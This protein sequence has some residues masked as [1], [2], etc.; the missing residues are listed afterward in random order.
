MAAGGKMSRFASAPRLPRSVRSTASRIPACRSA[1]APPHVPSSVVRLPR[2]RS[3]L[4]QRGRVGRRSAV[5]ARTGGLSSAY[6]R[7]TTTAARA[8]RWSTTRS[9]GH[10]RSRASS[11]LNRHA[12]R[13]RSRAPGP[14]HCAV[15]TSCSPPRR[16]SPDDAPCRH[17]RRDA[18]SKYLHGPGVWMLETLPHYPYA[19]AVLDELAGRRC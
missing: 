14:A 10:S 16:I 5:T 3:P 12:P 6:G 9:A 2:R 18:V 11:P 19:E 4:L 17:G 15:P 13:S 1:G 7:P 8:R